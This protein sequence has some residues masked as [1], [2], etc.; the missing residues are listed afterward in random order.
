VND[1]EYAA[2]L[3]AYARRLRD[4]CADRTTTATAV[5]AAMERRANALTPRPA[6]VV[7]VIAVGGRTVMVQRPRRSFRIAG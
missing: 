4:P 6:G 1:A 5:A 2:E 7:D 3:R